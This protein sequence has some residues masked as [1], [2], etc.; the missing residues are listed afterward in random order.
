[1]SH[2]TAKLLTF[3]IDGQ[4]FGIHA[5]H[6]IEIVRAVRIV[7]LPKA[8]RI[9]EGLIN[10]R[11][12]VV[13][14]LDIRSRFRLSPKAVE[15]SDH[16][17]VARAK[18]RIVGIR[19]DRALDVLMLLESDIDCINGIAPTSD[20]IAGVAKF[21]DGLLLIHDLATFL[22]EAEAEA[23]DELLPAGLPA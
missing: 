20:Y 13:P 4:R 22:S 8:P 2:A 7:G 18:E 6:V 9:V 15:P 3:A 16:I 1:M 10:L 17:V 5:D 11:G 21:P 12:A 19:V 14:V 23:L